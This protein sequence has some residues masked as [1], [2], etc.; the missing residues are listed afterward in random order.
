M[1]TLSAPDS[2]SLNVAGGFGI[3]RRITVAVAVMAVL[4]L[5]CGS[6]A[7]TADLSGAIISQGSVVIGRYVKKI[8]HKEGGIIAA[9]KVK[10]GD[11]VTSGASLISLDDTQTRAELGVIQSQLIEFRSRH[12]RFLAE[13]NGADQIVFPLELKIQPSA[14]PV[15]DGELQLFVENRKTRESQK[16]QLEQRVKQASEEVKGIH[17]QRDAKKME[18]VLISKELD[19]VRDLQERQLTPQTRVYQLEREQVRLAGEH[20]N[21]V[22]Q[23][24]RVAGQ[25]SE[26][27]LQILNLDQ[28][29]RTEAQRELRVTE[30][31]I[32]E[33]IER[34]VA[35][36]D[37]LM[38]MDVKAPTSGIVH[39]LG[40]HT[41]GGVVSP[42]EPILLIV[43]EGE[44]LEIELKI[45]PAD[46][47]QIAVGQEA[48][49]RFTA[50]NQ[51]TTPEM[52][53]II[54]FIAPDTTQDPKTRQDYF[55]VRVGLPAGTEWKIADRPITPGMPVEA[56]LTTG[57]R[58]AFSYLS[59]PITDQFSRT[60]R[61]R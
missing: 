24:A 21:F 32:S 18:L 25:I 27:N 1:T 35:A 34:E 57:K 46:I 42:A 43:P 11:T 16:Q 51:R 23:G 38:R 4:I 55:A 3:L 2:G 15:M 28:T 17:A 7:A 56:F 30:G 37:R 48:R 60:F 26:L 33:L 41:I 31:R 44:A 5:G 39:Q 61:E 49:L 9:I 6:W 10:N 13:R 40:M 12:A 54:T 19:K 45:S 53:G 59:K 36:V 29:A 8:Q 58:T 50:F 52:Q 22:A 14:R 47:D 20:G